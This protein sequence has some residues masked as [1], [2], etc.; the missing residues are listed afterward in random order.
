MKFQGQKRLTPERV[1]RDE[2]IKALKRKGY[3]YSE[4]KERFGLHESTI[5]SIC[6]GD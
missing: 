6:K 3:S 2:K 4:L 1:D 5:Y